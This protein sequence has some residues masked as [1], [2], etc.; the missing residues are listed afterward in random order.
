MVYNINGGVVCKRVGKVPSL[1]VPFFTA[2]MVF[3]CGSCKPDKL[4]KAI[5]TILEVPVPVFSEEGGVYN[6]DIA[7]E[8]ICELDGVTIYYTTDGSDPN[9]GCSAYEG[10]VEISGNGREL[11]LRAIAAR[12]DMQNS[13]IVEADFTIEYEPVSSPKFNIPGGLYTEDITVE[14]LCDT[15]NATIYYTDDGSPVSEKSNLYDPASPFEIQGPNAELILNAFAVCDGME[16]SDTVTHRYDVNYSSVAKPVFSPPGGIFT[17]NQSVSISCSTN[18]ATIYYDFSQSPYDEETLEPTPDAI[19]YVG[20]IPINNHGTKEFIIAYAVREQ[21]SPSDPAFGNYEIKEVTQD[22]SIDVASGTYQTDQTITITAP[23]SG[24]IIY[25]TTDGRD[26]TETDFDGSGGSPQIISV[27]GNGT[28]MTLK[29]MAVAPTYQ[30]TAIHERNYTIQYGTVAPPS[31]SPNG[32]IYDSTQNVTISSST[33]G[34]TIHYQVPGQSWQTGATPVTL[35]GY[36]TDGQIQAYASK[37]MML[38][39]STTTSNSFD[40]RPDITVG[41]G[42]PI[43]TEYTD[44]GNTYDF[45]FEENDG[46][47]GTASGYTTF[48]VRND[49]ADALQFI[50]VSITGGDSGSYDL[51]T[52]STVSSLAPGASTTFRV[53]FD[54]VAYGTLS[55]AAVEITSN[56]PN[57]DPFSFGL[58]GA[59]Y[60]NSVYVST[61][62]SSGN[63]GFTS[64][65]ALDDIQD[66]IN[67]AD[68]LNIPLVK[69]SQGTYTIS[70]TITAAPGVSLQGGWNTSF[71]SRNWTSYQTKIYSTVPQSMVKVNDAAI[72]GITIEGFYFEMNHTSGSGNPRGIVVSNEA[73]ATLQDNHIYIRSTVSN[74]DMTYGARVYPQNGSSITVRRNTIISSRSNS[75]HSTSAGEAVYVSSGNGS[76]VIEQN[77][78]TSYSNNSKRADGIHTVIL[79][80]VSSLKTISYQF[81]APGIWPWASFLMAAVR[82]SRSATIRFTP[83]PPEITNSAFISHKAAAPAICEQY[84]SF[85]RGRRLRRFRS[86]VGILHG[87]G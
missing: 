26:P 84:L 49:G 60:G 38:D 74:T 31:F 7:V 67:V 35:S 18:N 68:T 69:V 82:I 45:G 63:T 27:A 40:F 5:N 54:P 87:A 17:T 9:T 37:T 23:Q 47:G 2:S 33:G 73:S 11:T 71:S 39:S 8:I 55:N 70:S 46:S 3:L 80:Q 81:T 85:R 79:I 72:S 16:P 64:A 62:G 36:S 13:P 21:L 48:T 19:E 65:D 50:G 59:G 77:V 86:D 76:V 10:P 61:S 29:A 52:G 34:A 58:D 56:D 53:R 12:E 44:G 25:Y 30:P 75:T 78:I 57:E 6:R 43:T 20:T 24:S 83:I 22:I 15:A 42:D 66:A 1:S 32:G 51:D 41:E 28:T 14:I 4:S